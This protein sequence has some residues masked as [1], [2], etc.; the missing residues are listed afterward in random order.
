MAAAVGGQ[1]DGGGLSAGG[2]IVPGSRHR[3][4]TPKRSANEARRLPSVH[5][6]APGVIRVD[7]SSDMSTT[8]IHTPTRAQPLAL[9]EG[10][11]LTQ[12]RQIARLQQAEESGIS[13]GPCCAVESRPERGRGTPGGLVSV[14]PLSWGICWCG[15]SAW[16]SAPHHAPP[17]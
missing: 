13:N 11:D 9:D 12:A 16:L 7:A 6:R 17:P 15:P 4:A 8:P 2:A 10:P 1:A 3:W 5:N 14:L